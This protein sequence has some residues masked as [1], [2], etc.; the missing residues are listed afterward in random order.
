LPSLEKAILIKNVGVKLK[1]L[2]LNLITRPGAGGVK[3]ML[4]KSVK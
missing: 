3:I 2:K 1:K 4:Y